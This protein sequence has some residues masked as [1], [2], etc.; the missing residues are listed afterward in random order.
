MNVSRFRMELDSARGRESFEAP[1]KYRV[2]NL[3]TERGR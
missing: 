2:V 1:R 3:T